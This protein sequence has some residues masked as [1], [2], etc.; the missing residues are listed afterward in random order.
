M[1]SLAVSTSTTTGWSGPSSI[2]FTPSTLTWCCCTAARPRARSWSPPNGPTTARFRRA[3]N[4]RRLQRHAWYRADGD[5]FAHL[6]DDLRRHRRD[7]RQRPGV[8]PLHQNGRA[9][10]SRTGL[11][12]GVR[13]SRRQGGA[14]SGIKYARRPRRRTRSEGGLASRLTPSSQSTGRRGG[15]LR[16]F[17]EVARSHAY[18]QRS[19]WQGVRPK[20][21][22]GNRRSVGLPGR[23]RNPV[24]FTGQPLR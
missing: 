3:R 22:L 15:S 5:A 20:I 14:G 16:R 24:E 23:G 12:A 9:R 10:T 17:A 21:G 8:R 6:A 18:D 1:H 2:R 13:P 11:G 19:A 4:R 7:R